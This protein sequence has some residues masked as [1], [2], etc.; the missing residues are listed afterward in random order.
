MLSVISSLLPNDVL[1][2]DLGFRA[3]AF[4]VLG[5]CRLGSSATTPPAVDR[6]SLQ[7]LR[8]LDRRANL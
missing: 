4:K 8:T 7:V 5:C 2:V 3:L 1:A 6:E